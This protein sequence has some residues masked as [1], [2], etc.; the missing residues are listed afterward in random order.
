[1]IHHTAT[2]RIWGLLIL[3]I[4]YP[5]VSG[6]QEV[7]TL[8]E[9]AVS[10]RDLWGE[11]ALKLPGGPTYEFFR[12]LL[13]PLR[14]VDARFRC[15]PIVLSAPSNPAKARLVSDGSSINARERSLSWSKEQGTPC[16]FFM[17]DKREVFGSDL[18]KLQ[19]PAFVDGYLPIVRM[20]YSSQ[21]SV[22]EQESF[23]S[24][25]PALADNGVVF[26]KFTLKEAKP[27]HFPKPK[28][29]PERQDEAVKGV[30]N[31]ENARLIAEPYDDRIEA[32]FEGPALYKLDKGR[33]MAPS[34]NQEEQ[35]AL[36]KGGK[37]VDKIESQ[38]LALSYPGW[39]SN[40]G[41]GAIIAQLKVGQSV[42]VAVFTKKADPNSL[43]IKLTPE[44]YEKQRAQCIKT[45]ND[46]LDAGIGLETPE[47]V[48]NDCW[49]AHVIMN[50]MLITGDAI[51]YSACN[52]YDGIY[53]AEGG[54]A[55]YAMGLFGYSADAQRLMPAQFKAQ[56]KGLEFHR[57]AFKLQ[58]L[59]KCYR[60]HPDPEYVTKIEP[61]WQKEIDVILNGRESSSGMLPKE[62]YCGDV[63]TYVYS[64]NSNSNCWRALREM[65]VLC[66]ETGR[67]EQAQKLAKVAEEYRKTILAALDKAIDRSVDPPFVPVALSGEEDP[68]QPIWGTTMGSYWNLMIHYILASGVFPADSK[69]AGDVLR[70]V[71]QHGGLAM[72]MLRARETPGNFWVDGPRV[73]DLYGLRRN[74]VLLQRDE[75]DLALVAFYGK[76]AQGQTR[77]TFIGCEGSSLVPVDSYGRQM[78]LP[79]NSSANSNYMETL[80]YLLV[81]DYDLN[82]DGRVET[83][84]LA[85]A[86]PQAWLANGKQIKVK[87][88]PT[89]FGDVSFTLTSNLADG[90]VIA[91]LDLPTR[92]KPEK[93]FLRLRL[94]D[95]KKIASA[96]A[97][98][99]VLK[100]DGET[101]DISSLSG[102]ISLRA[103]F[104]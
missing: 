29:R 63:H 17:G 6:A 59:A 13:P 27:A 91:D 78:F 90:N 103:E 26:V 89:A 55:I 35:F 36:M 14:Y 34:L 70:Y 56:R 25:D 10:P 65:S 102:K 80:R 28:I 7:A 100:V 84:R 9:I 43:K 95:G 39:I 1:M 101:I 5:Q 21:G 73:N 77:D 61:M 86:T 42:Y 54:D 15:Y 24:I 67:T 41:R 99:Q 62:Q 82:D 60:L 22:W 81:Q 104:Q 12:D 16:Y 69:M 30:E 44:E 88:A 48:V 66:A 38:V 8:K 23:C 50:F 18:S 45:W 32:W 2:H 74:L 4:L 3:A 49:R 20:T 51:H 46:V 94:P 52:Q 19:G 83:L 57:A 97:G 31:A 76:L 98:E 93:A 47:K 68:H 11:A 92:R 79:P 72:G 33:V 87:R 37:T 40:P 64:L 58:M 71:E 96:R 53:I 75:V 85:F